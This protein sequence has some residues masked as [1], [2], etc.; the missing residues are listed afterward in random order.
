M[1][2]WTTRQGGSSGAVWRHELLSAREVWDMLAERATG[3]RN[4]VRAPE[5]GQRGRGPGRAILRNEPGQK[6]EGGVRGGRGRS[7]CACSAWEGP[8]KVRQCVSMCCSICGLGPA[9]ERTIVGSVSGRSERGFRLFERSDTVFP[10]QNA[11]NGAESG[12]NV[13]RARALGR[14]AELVFGLR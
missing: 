14:L 1:S 7:L 11:V 13:P 10:K 3:S 5:S 9:E 6:Q 12:K 2:L 8:A 4:G